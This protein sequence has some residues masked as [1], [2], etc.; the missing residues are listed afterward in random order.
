MPPL[1]RNGGGYSSVPPRGAGDWGA[2]AMPLMQPSFAPMPQSVQTPRGPIFNAQESLEK[3]GT[4]TKDPN[5]PYADV[6]KMNFSVGNPASTAGENLTHAQGL[7]EGFGAGAGRLIGGL[8]GQEQ[9]GADIGQFIGKIGQSPLDVAGNV[10]GAIPALPFLPGGMGTMS[11]LTANDQT[12]AEYLKDW[13]GNPFSFFRA[14]G[15]HDKEEW[16]KKI[17]SGEV[18]PLLHSMGGGATMGDQLMNA[19]GITGVLSDVIQRGW[20]GGPGDAIKRVME[21]KEGELSP[22]VMALRD[23]YKAGEISH[24]LFLDKLTVSGAG[25]SNNWVVNLLGSAVLDPANLLLGAGTAIGLASKGAK[26]AQALKFADEV[27]EVGMKALMRSAAEQATLKGVN[28]AE[29]AV[30]PLQAMQEAQRLGSHGAQIANAAKALPAHS[31][32]A[33]HPAFGH[34]ER[35]AN[36][37]QKILDPFSQI[38]MRGTKP[39][40][41]AYLS[42]EMTHAVAETFGLDNYSHLGDTMNQIGKGD[43]FDRAIGYFGAQEGVLQAGD[44][45]TKDVANIRKVSDARP[46]TIALER[47]KYGTGTFRAKSVRWL[48]RRKADYA[49]LTGGTKEEAMARATNHATDRLTRMGLTPEEAAR[50]IKGLDE[51]GLSLVDAMYFGHRI[52]TYNVAKRSAR[53][54]IAAKIS[55]YHG[56]E[57]G[58]KKLTDLQDFADRATLIGPRELTD[59][60]ADA[61][62]ESLKVGDIEAVRNA[63][64]QYDRLA[65]QFLADGGEDQVLIK[66]VREWLDEFDGGLTKELGP[67]GLNR[68]PVEM[69]NDALTGDGYVYG[70]RPS[71]GEDEWRLAFHTEE[72]A[73]ADAASAVPTG[74]KSGDI[75]S[76]NPWYDI[77]GDAAEPWNLKFREDGGRVS[78]FMNALERK[79]RMVGQ[80]ITSD[81]ID[82]VVRRRFVESSMLKYDPEAKAYIGNGL[83]YNEARTL[84]DGVKQRAL[85]ASTSPRGM[86]LEEFDQII[87]SSPAASRVGL[88]AR[89]L[90]MNTLRSFEGNVGTVGLSQKL[91]GKIKTSTATMPFLPENV[92]GQMSERMYPMIRFSINPLFQ[93]QEWVEPWVFAAARGRKAMLTGGW[94]VYDPVSQTTRHVGLDDVDLIQEH[95]IDRYRASSQEAQFDMMERSLVYLHGQKAAKEAAAATDTNIFRRAIRAGAAQSAGE[96]KRQSQSEMFR[97]FL[98]PM[99]KESFDKIN[100][101]IWI[102]LEREFGT[103]DLGTIAVRWISE[104]D[105]WASADPRVAFH[106][107]DTAKQPALGARAAVNLEENAQRVFSSSR[108]R[109]NERV[110]IGIADAT[111]ADAL[112]RVE[113]ED[114]MNEVGAHPDYI[115]R[116]WKTMQFEAKTGGLDQWYDDAAK[117][118]KGGKQEVAAVRTVIQALA[119]THGVSEM[120][121]LSRSIQRSPV[122]LLHDD[123]IAAS[124]ADLDGWGVLLQQSQAMTDYIRVGADGGISVNPM[125]KPLADEEFL[126]A[127]ANPPSTIPKEQLGNLHDMQKVS[128]RDENGVGRDVFIPGGM[129]ALN[130][131]ETPWTA[132]EAHFIRAQV[133]NPEDMPNAAL[134]HALDEKMWRGHT[135]DMADPANMHAVFNNYNFALHS[136]NMTLTRNEMVATRFRANSMKDVE[137]LANT[138]TSLR[139]VIESSGSTK[140]LVNDLGLAYSTTPGISHYIPLDARR[141]H[142]GEHMLPARDTIEAGKTVHVRS[143]ESLVEE[144]AQA[145]SR[146]LRGTTV[147]SRKRFAEMEAAKQ[148]G[149]LH[150]WATEQLADSIF[151]G[152]KSADGTVIKGV[153]ALD[154]MDPIFA[155]RKRAASVQNV[156]EL[157]AAAARLVD[158]P[159]DAEAR[160]MLA[161]YVSAW[162]D[163]DANV[164][165][166]PWNVNGAGRTAAKGVKGEP[167]FHGDI[168][169][170][171]AYL[172]NDDVSWRSTGTNANMGNSLL[173]AQD[174]HA[175][176]D[177][178]VRRK[179]ADGSLEPLDEFGE[180][181]SHRTRGLQLKTG[182]FGA[183][184][185]DPLNFPK[186][187]HDLHMVGDMT[188]WMYYTKGAKGKNA[189]WKK[190]LGT[191]SPAKQ[192]E[193]NEWVAAGAKRGAGKFD[194]SEASGVP[195]TFIPGAERKALASATKAERGRWV[196]RKL[197]EAVADPKRPLISQSQRDRMGRMYRTDEEW[198]ELYDRDIRMYGGD[199]QVFEDAMTLRKAEAEAS[200][201]VEGELL[202]RHGNGGY[203]WK[204]WDERRHVWDPETTAF[205]TSHSAP[206]RDV[207]YFASSDDA[208]NV[209]GFYNK[210]GQPS[211]AEANHSVLDPWNTL[212]HQK[213]DGGVIRGATITTD[214]GEKIIGLTQYRNKSTFLHEVVH[215]VIEPLV[216]DPSLKRVVWDD[217]N[218]GITARNAAM[219]ART[220]ELKTQ[221]A[222]AAS[223]VVDHEYALMES[224]AR[225]DP[226]VTASKTAAGELKVAEKEAARLA[227]EVPKQQGILAQ[228]RKANP[229]REQA[230]KRMKYKSAQD[231]ALNSAEES[232]RKQTQLVDDLVAE[233]KA[234][235][236]TLDPL[237]QT[238]QVADEAQTAAEQEV[239][240]LSSV[241]KKAKADGAKIR[242]EYDEIAT[243]AP[244]EIKYGWDRDVSEHFAD[245]FTKWMAT[246]EAKNPKMRD[247]FAYFRNVLVRLFKWSKGQPGHKVS[248]EL[249]ELFNDLTSPKVAERMHMANAVPFDATEEALHAVAVQ[250]VADA[251]DSAFTNVQFRRSRSWLERSIN[252]PYFG[253]YP[254][255]YMWGKVAPEMIRGLAVNPFGIPIPILTK[256]VKINGIEVGIHG[257]PFAGFTNAQRVQNA[258]ELQKDTDPEFNAAVNDPTNDQMF[259]NAM[260]FLPASPWE[261]PANFS[262]WTRRVAE[263]GLEAQQAA[264]EGTKAPGFNVPGVAS[265]VVSYAF[266]PKATLDWL[267]QSAKGIKNMATRDS[268]GVGSAT[269][270]GLEIKPNAPLEQSLGG[271]ATQLQNALTPRP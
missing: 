206:K 214:T 88:S 60:R 265:D 193:I 3:Y 204:L 44:S 151:N 157:E 192:T 79:T 86:S 42:R 31:R 36:A 8:V 15:D 250:R 49:M 6:G 117:L 74:I 212:L 202:K 19:L 190:W 54:A 146:Y 253:I 4:S 148:G 195:I 271:A 233:Q 198:G 37:S 205:A 70:L 29:E 173:F 104:K 191:L 203:Q 14:I 58:M 141:D 98:G 82:T 9:A 13:D 236:A 247:A 99:L 159:M 162:K 227:T 73:L 260:M 184:L 199:Y 46:A 17:D 57:A 132:I 217:L 176:P 139:S 222:D 47:A 2:E 213:G 149:P 187:V 137:D 78:T 160:K 238:K 124:A 257:S 216:M 43:L 175:N 270:G 103:K 154:H 134:R 55:G 7:V 185:G 96:R 45:L 85:D 152:V 169:D 75:K 158:D 215:S 245:E 35:V 81:K 218:A 172:K 171:F 188:E 170:T 133:L 229:A 24:D 196:R 261:A 27:G 208:H 163:H 135:I 143:T 223:A 71:N 89:D 59:L 237:R 11:F 119:E 179:L 183:D 115:D 110:K 16:Q 112:T 138:A 126:H 220:G 77:V 87:K 80:Q 182:F 167:I 41:N 248:P 244:E 249:E 252:H 166:K 64:R 231:R 39:L 234:H 34:M 200:G 258:V 106:V 108:E 165:F 243:K 174:M 239:A 1:S 111:H 177:F 131:L 255:S 178:Y 93:L 66:G 94:D 38:G 84:Y 262:L 116:T 33:L 121:L 147:E 120:E 32:A 207:R 90:M 56:G 72:E 25:Y 256:P 219:V 63:V 241:L 65:V 242:A 155:V 181:I 52:S 228:M 5:R 263:Y 12:R 180:R 95:M 225:L 246:G 20:A 83:T 123:L 201:S 209:G 156:E 268:T 23:Q 254:S 125:F 259:R 127:A 269:T 91:T 22:E 68:L 101:N 240:N 129:D 61:L 50:V 21:A 107:M 51:D 161:P 197:D 109:L 251:E 266:G 48:S 28:L 130:D 168:N 226:L 235:A 122:S 10:L 221:V 26:A 97:H 118:A 100:P 267:D 140:P 53:E 153:D 30:T 69:R 105:R 145:S 142:M 113:F 164:I 102:D 264:Q 194:W 92:L 189:A 136:A 186:G 230:A 67:D 211:I 76:A 114:M 210:L 18:N 62:R 40:E 128:F 232:L 144:R 224:Q 150:N